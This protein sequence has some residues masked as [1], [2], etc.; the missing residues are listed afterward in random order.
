MMNFIRNL[1]LHFLYKYKYN[2]TNIIR[3]LSFLS[4]R[5]DYDYFIAR[6]RLDYTLNFF[7]FKLSND[8]FFF[9]FEK[10]ILRGMLDVIFLLCYIDNLSYYYIRKKTIKLLINFLSF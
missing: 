6:N 2:I 10:F 5:Y 9:A 4:Q 8:D 1:I 7:I 3:S